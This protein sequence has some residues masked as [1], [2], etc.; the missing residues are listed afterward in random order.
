M[1]HG[2]WV[3]ASLPSVTHMGATEATDDP[4]KQLNRAESHR[5]A[6]AEAIR[7]KWADPEYRERNLQGKAKNLEAKPKVGNLP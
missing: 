2:A 4:V 7:R 3:S 6:I 1:Q 5:A